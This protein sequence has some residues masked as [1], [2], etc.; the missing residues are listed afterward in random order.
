MAHPTDYQSRPKKNPITKTQRKSIAILQM[1]KF[2]DESKNWSEKAVE[3]HCLTV[4]KE[5]GV[6]KTNFKNARSLWHKINVS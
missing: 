3:E 4:Y 2:F 1:L 6:N 5:I